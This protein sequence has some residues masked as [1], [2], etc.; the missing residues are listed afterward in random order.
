MSGSARLKCQATPDL[1]PGAAGTTTTGRATPEQQMSGNAP[2]LT[3]IT[4]RLQ[5]PMV[6]QRILATRHSAWDDNDKRCPNQK[7][8]GS[9]K[10]QAMP[11]L[12]KKVKQRL[13]KQ[14]QEPRSLPE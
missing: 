9:E 4:C 10:C 11:D 1:K 3:H 8:T 2:F 14:C 7:L 5:R 13:V 12:K 6:K